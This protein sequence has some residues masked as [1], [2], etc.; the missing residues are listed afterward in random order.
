MSWRDLRV[1]RFAI[2]PVVIFASQLGVAGAEA[3]LVP[4][5]AGEHTAPP[6]GDAKQLARILCQFLG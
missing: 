5:V 6:R 4:R 2:L 3:R 1:F